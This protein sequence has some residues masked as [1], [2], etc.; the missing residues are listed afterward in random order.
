MRKRVEVLHRFSFYLLPSTV[1]LNLFQGLLN[2]MNNHNYYV[3]I[4]TNFLNTTFYIGVTNNLERR[5]AEHK[6]ELVDGFTKQYHLTKLIYFEHYPRI[7]DAIKREKNYYRSL[8]AP[9]SFY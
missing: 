2:K 4:L 6:I 5:I 8:R 1:T 7:E 9:P 3:Y